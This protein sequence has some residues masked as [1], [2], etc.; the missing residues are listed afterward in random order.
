MRCSNGNKGRPLL[1][2]TPFLGPCFIV[3]QGLQIVEKRAVSGSTIWNFD[4]LEL[5][6]IFP[7]FP[8]TF[9]IK[10]VYLKSWHWLNMDKQV[11]WEIILKF[12]ILIFFLFAKVIKHVFSRTFGAKIGSTI[13]EF[14]RFGSRRFGGLGVYDN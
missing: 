3:H 5:P 2:A 1:E 6:G 12:R 9:E 10:I 4:D 14:R 13:F 11:L 8:G 7:D